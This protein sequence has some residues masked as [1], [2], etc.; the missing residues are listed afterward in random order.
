[1]VLWVWLVGG[2]AMIFTGWDQAIS[3]PTGDHV[4]GVVGVV[5]GAV[6]VTL[7]LGGLLIERRW[8]RR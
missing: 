4:L 2:L 7:G 6:T 1:L 8:N 3:N 5:L